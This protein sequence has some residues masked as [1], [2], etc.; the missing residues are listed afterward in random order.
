MF[1]FLDRKFIIDFDNLIIL[2]VLCLDLAILNC[3]F[4]S[5]FDMI[6]SMLQV[7]IVKNEQGGNLV[8]TVVLR[9]STYS[10]LDDLERGVDDG[11][12]KYK[13]MYRDIRILLGAGATEI[14][15][16][17]KLKEFVYKETGLDKYAIGKF[18]ERFELVPRTLAENAGLN[19]TKIISSLYAEHVSGNISVG[20]DLDQGLF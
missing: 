9:G 16:A 15:L 20:I 7:T 17:R 13:A 3:Q 12:N 1:T 18:A 11:V 4:K 19:A 5:Y 6:P 14:D 8:S 10:I 2:R